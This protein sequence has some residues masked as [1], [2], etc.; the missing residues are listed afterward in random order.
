M[1]NATPA[2]S[3]WASPR[4]PFPH[5]ANPAA[6]TGIA[7]VYRR[8]Q[9]TATPLHRRSSAEYGVWISYP[10][11]EA[12]AATGQDGYPLEEAAAATG[13]DGYRPLADRYAALGREWTALAEAAL[14]DDVPEL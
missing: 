11:E 14:P 7:A 9:P 3:I 13:Q 8:R 10:L 6:P 12:A 1:G 5:A 2:R 4:G